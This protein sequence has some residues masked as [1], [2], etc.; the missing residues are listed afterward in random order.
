MAAAVQW[1]YLDSN[2]KMFVAVAAVTRQSKIFGGDPGV[3][4]L[5]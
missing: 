2:D 5:L 1:S 4:S 3:N